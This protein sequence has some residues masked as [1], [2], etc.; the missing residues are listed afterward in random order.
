ML[1]LRRPLCS[2]SPYFRQCRA[3]NYGRLPKVHHVKFKRP[4]VRRF[5]KTC[6]LYGAAF[7]LWSQLLV[8]RF[9]GE[10][11][12]DSLEDTAVNKN[13]S[14]GVADDIIEEDVIFI[15]LGLPCKR[16]GELYALSD[17]E[18]Q[19]FL[20]IGGNKQRV[21][22]LQDE[23]AA[24]V[25]KKA[26]GL[27]EVGHL[28]GSPLT[29]DEYWLVHSFR[30]RAPS[31]YEQSG[32][33]IS[34]THVSWVSRPIS[35]EQGD[36]IWK[37][38]LPLAVASALRDAW[39][40][41]WKKQ[42]QRFERPRYSNSSIIAMTETALQPNTESSTEK[43]LPSLS[44]LEMLSPNSLKEGLPHNESP[45][46]PHP[47][48]VISILQ[49]LPF[50]SFVPGSDLLLASMAFKLSLTASRS[51]YRPTPKRG[52]FYFNGTVGLKGPRGSCRFEVCGEYDPATRSWTTV[53]MYLKDFNL[54]TQRPLGRS[55]DV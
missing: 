38:L 41:L 31:H 30:Y 34:D 35:P 2:P 28:L 12:M 7:H 33:E 43:D 3:F 24:T 46:R 27:P 26:S 49:R 4:W 52:V 14:Q 1:R 53:N 42:L 54:S 13:L 18:W 48:L 16:P 51:R 39:K 21:K 19:E 9:D 37:V 11:K 10:V 15:P 23:L 40:V 5:A 29:L 32:L 44:D 22:S 6:L 50:P 20:K 17:A 8:L 45:A 47:S 55:R 25:W 36:R